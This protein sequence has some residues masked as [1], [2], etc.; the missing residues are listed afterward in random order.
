MKKDDY[1]RLD[2]VK[3]FT[4]WFA[5][6]EAQ[7]LSHN[8]YNVAKKSNVFFKDLPDAL[9]KYEWRGNLNKNTAILRV[10]QNNLN[11]AIKTQDFLGFRDASHE[12]MKWGGTGRGNND[13]LGKE[14]N[15]NVIQETLQLLKSQVDDI[16]EIKQVDNLRFNSGLTKVYSLIADDFIIYDSRV[17]AALA[18]YVLKFIEAENKDKIPEELKFACMKAKGGKQLR[19]PDRK[20]VV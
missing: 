16:N 14:G 19:N 5:T 4:K 7:S 9:N 20:S 17:A 3:A 6:S 10:I 8:Y 18:W 2:A 13:W 15:F 12:L 1:L 11:A